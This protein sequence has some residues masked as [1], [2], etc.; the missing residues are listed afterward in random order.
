MPRLTINR[1]VSFDPTIFQIMEDR[2]SKLL[3]QRSE[4]LTKLILQDMK[5]RGKAMMVEEVDP[6]IFKGAPSARDRATLSIDGSKR[7][8]SSEKKK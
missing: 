3:M 6:E 1:S 8:R 7:K 4:Y 5:L 2:R